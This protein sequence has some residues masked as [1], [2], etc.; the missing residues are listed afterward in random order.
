MAWWRV[1]STLRRSSLRGLARQPWQTGLTLLGIALGVAI[2]VAVDLANSSARRAFALSLSSVSGVA[3]HQ[4]VGGPLGVDDRVFA[5]LRS[6]LG[7]R[8]NAPVVL[9]SASVAARRFTLLGVDLFSERDLGRHDALLDNA[10][11]APAAG[12]WRGD[13]VAMHRAA[14]RELGVAVGE[15]IELDLGERRV[16]VAV[17]ALFG[18][19]AGAAAQGLLLADIALAQE[20]LLRQGYIDRIDLQLDEAGQQRVRAW[21]PPGL[22]LLDSGERNASLRQMSE[23]FHLNLTAMSLLALLVAGLLIYNTVTF[24][25]LRRRRV[26]GIYRALGVSRGELFALVGAEAGLMGLAGS[27]GGLL[28]GLLLGQALL[29]LVTRTIDDLY[30]HLHVTTF[31]VD[32]WSLLKGLALGLAVTALAAA[33]PAREA[34]LSPP[35]SVQQRSSVER[36]SRGRVLLLALVGLGALGAGWLA[37][38]RDGGSLSQGFAG[39]VVQVLGYCLIVPALVLLLARG[40]VGALPRRA[41]VVP[42]LALRGIEAGISRTGLAVAALTVAVSVTVGVGIMVGSFR[43]TVAQWL[44]QTLAGDVYVASLNPHQQPLPEALQRRLERLPEVGAVS[45]SRHV[46]LETA[47]GPL[48]L[49]VR[50][51]APAEEAQFA[52]R[53]ALADP[54]PAFRRGGGVMISEPLAWHQGLAPGAVVT[55]PTPDGARAFPVLGVFADYSSSRGVLM[56]ALEPYASIW[57]DAAVSGLVLSARA[58]GGAKALLTAVEEQ[59][60]AAGGGFRATA[61]GAIREQSLAVFDRTFAITHVLRLLALVVAFVGVLSALLALQLERSRE[62]AV[63]RATGMTPW[64][65]GRLVVLQ[66]GVTGLIAGVLALPLGLLM[67]AILIDV[68]N[69]RSFGWTMEHHLP[70]GVLLEALA[71]A[72]VAAVLAGIYPAWRAARAAP[73]A[74]LREE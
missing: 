35:L 72:V 54:W 43:D 15:V 45:R 53:S 32:P 17:R 31:V 51:V 10:A 4:L 26:L 24:S 71:L 49:T 65:L 28:L 67:S 16:P 59:L 69:R 70:P 5:R 23:A 36:R 48:R 47:F 52:L 44:T 39:L 34:A 61:S 40:G 21:L 74:A 25:V 2:V 55:L 41:G 68:I 73:A 13:G 6:E 37:M 33:L 50:D 3:T 60:A 8:A 9:G 12:L 56:M 62:Y 46:R 18:A 42:R 27:A 20:L 57:R 1:P 29:R 64:Q 22:T 63:L 38:G 19:E 14:A 66:T 7:L 58:G 11:D 30:F